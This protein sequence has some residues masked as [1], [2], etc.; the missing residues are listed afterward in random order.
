MSEKL[1]L[2][3]TSKKQILGPVSREKVIELIE[4]GALVD[5]DEITRGNGY[6]FQ[7]REKDLL[8]KYLYGDIVQE[9]NPISEAPDILTAPGAMKDGT[10]TIDKIPGL[11]KSKPTPSAAPVAID[12]ETLIPGGDDLEYPDMGTSSSEN[13]SGEDE[14]KVPDSDDLDY[15]DLDISR[16]DIT[17]VVAAPKA[18]APP[19]VEDQT[20]VLTID[21]E[22]VH[23]PSSDDLEY[24][25]MGDM[26]LESA[27]PAPTEDDL[28]L[29]LEEDTIVMEP[30]PQPEPEPEPELPTTPPPAEVAPVVSLNRKATPQSAVAKALGQSRNVVSQAPVVEEEIDDELE[31]DIEDDEEL[32]DEDEDEDEFDAEEDTDPE[33]QSPMQGRALKREVRIKRTYE[34][35]ARN[36]RYLFVLL[37][38]VLVV[39]ASGILYYY[40]KILGKPLPFLS[41]VFIPS[42]QAQTMAP[43]S[44][45]PIETTNLSKKKTLLIKTH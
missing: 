16:P 42:V 45:T 5:K 28:A 27:L 14:V 4:K 12:D 37:A 2:I 39:L 43:Q 24:P 26:G 18:P 9:F 6:W 30:E 21:G 38:L 7:L 17:M 44:A 15:P 23:I 1:W 3:R 35:P 10:G 40:S 19:V 22:E 32:E 20:T 13:P 33:R 11:E 29:N 8:D 31:E 41:E 25:D 34:A 36:D